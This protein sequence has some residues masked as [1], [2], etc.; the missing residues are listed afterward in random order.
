MRNYLIA[1]ASAAAIGVAAPN[2]DAAELEIQLTG[3]DVFLGFDGKF[4]IQTAP[5]AGPR[6]DVEAAT[7]FVDGVEIATVV[8]DIS[9]GI[10]LPGF[11]I[12]VDGGTTTNQQEQGYFNLDLDT[13]IGGEG[14]LNLNVGSSNAVTAFY[15]G[16]EIG[17][18]FI[19]EADFLAEQEP[20]TR[21]PNWPGFND[22]DLITFSFVSTN[23]TDVE[24]NGH[25]LTQFRASGAGTVNGNAIPEPATAGLL[26]VAG[27]TALRRRRA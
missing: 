23:I 21:V 12:P 14:W 2:A 15:T 17:I 19:G 7:F 4:N 8:G 22:F 24:D 5:T 13:T 11:L 6:D 26:A 20:L 3:L 18:S 9:A 16:N 27:L 25:S 10:G 1:A